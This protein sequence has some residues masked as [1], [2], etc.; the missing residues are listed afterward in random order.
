MIRKVANLMELHGI[1]LEIRM[2]ISAQHDGMSVATLTQIKNV[3]WLLPYKGT[4]IQ[5]GVHDEV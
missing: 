4:S 2:E 3:D 5:K 1:S